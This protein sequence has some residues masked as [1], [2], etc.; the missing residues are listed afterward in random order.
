MED[1]IFAIILRCL[2]VF[3]IGRLNE[4]GDNDACTDYKKIIVTLL[5]QLNSMHNY[6]STTVPPTD[7]R[8]KN[9]GRQLNV[10]EQK[11]VEHWTFHDF[12]FKNFN[13][14]MLVLKKEDL[15]VDVEDY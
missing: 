10:I 6:K 14:L 4:K 3:N 7:L 1:R 15:L 8:I 9:I 2:G 11:P 13:A 12:Y 5:S